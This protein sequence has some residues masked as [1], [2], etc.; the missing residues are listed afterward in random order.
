MKETILC[1]LLCGLL[2]GAPAFGDTVIL[3]DGA[4]Y[5]VSSTGFW[6]VSLYSWRR[7]GE[8]CYT[9]RAKRPCCYTEGFE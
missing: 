1:S 9:K 3:R 7:P 6:P 5:S 4:G 2:F 8:T